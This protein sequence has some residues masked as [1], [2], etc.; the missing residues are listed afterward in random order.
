MKREKFPH[1]ILVV[2]NEIDRVDRDGGEDQGKETVSQD[3]LRLSG[4]EGPGLKAEFTAGKDPGA[5]RL[6]R[7]D[8]KVDFDWTFDSPF[9]A[10]AKGRPVR[11]ALQLPAGAWKAEWIDVFTG[12]AA[13]TEEFTHEGGERILGSPPFGGPAFKEDIALKVTAAAAR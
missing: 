9:T 2:G 10:G 7:T 4:A 8:P 1:A 12:Q 6:E 13:L 11:I 5:G 3:C